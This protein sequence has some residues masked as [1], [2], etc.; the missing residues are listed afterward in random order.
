MALRP[1][2]VRCC[3]KGQEGELLEQSVLTGDVFRRGAA[4]EKLVDEFFVDG[5]CH[6][7]PLFFL[8][9]GILK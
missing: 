7:V 5:L 8:Q 2:P 3:C 6:P 4:L 1:K 9:D